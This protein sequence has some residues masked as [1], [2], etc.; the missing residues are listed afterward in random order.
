[1]S[2]NKRY[3]YKED[4]DFEAVERH[5]KGDNTDTDD[6][7]ASANLFLQALFIACSLTEEERICFTEVVCNSKSLRHVSSMIC[8][9]HHTVG[10]RV[11]SVCTKIRQSPVGIQMGLELKRLHI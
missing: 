4:F 11:A 6:K 5:L 8:R 2:E 10:Q 9:D 7:Y 1:M 3:E